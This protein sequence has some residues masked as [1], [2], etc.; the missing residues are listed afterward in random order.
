MTDSTAIETDW[1]LRS[2][3]LKKLTSQATPDRPVALGSSPVPR[4]LVQYWDEREVPDD[5]TKCLAS[6]GSL[7]SR[8]FTRLLF[9]R[10]RGRNFILHAHGDEH[11]A[12][13]D[14][15]PHPAARSDYF[16]L[17]YLAVQ[18]GWYVDADDQFQDADIGSLLSPRGLR[19][20]ALCY[21]IDAGNTI[22]PRAALQGSDTRNVIHYVNN[23]PI[24]TRPGHPI[25]TEALRIATA[26]LNQYTRT[27]DTHFDIQAT[28]GPGLLT[29]T[30]AKYGLSSPLTSK[31]LDVEIRTDWDVFAQPVW[32]LTYRR[33][34]YD[35]RSWD[36]LRAL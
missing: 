27:P 15:A 16:R 9:D 21:D 17:C 31:E 24:I 20:Q 2:L 13:F 28:A 35:W 3:T 10:H 18:G 25:I 23:N 19:V 29:L 4:V 34:G 11:A 8:G 6:W 12:A 32:D 26:T 30:I 14:A 36:G 33:S 7:E 5:V 1:Q 22:D